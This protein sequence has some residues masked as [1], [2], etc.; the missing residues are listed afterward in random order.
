MALAL[1]LLLPKL[2]AQAPTASYPNEDYFWTHSR[3]ESW[4]QINDTYKAVVERHDQQLRRLKEEYTRR[5]AKARGDE[6]QREVNDWHAGAVRELELQAGKD[7]LRKE[8]C[9]RRLNQFYADLFYRENSPDPAVRERVRA[10][11]EMR[12]K[13]PY[14]ESEGQ[15]P[16]TMPEMVPTPGTPSR[17][18]P[19]LVNAPASQSMQRRWQQEVERHK[20]ELDRIA[21]SM[22][23]E[24]R[25]HQLQV[26]HAGKNAELLARE[27]SLHAE[28]LR[29][30][31]GE[32]ARETRRFEEA[33]KR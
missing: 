26:D 15:D 2:L 32:L 33:S 16:R 18:S 13:G 3:E 11:R 21:E 22:N 12:R 29:V 8:E 31:L 6:A 25:A 9:Q 20:R 19:P 28:R 23:Q 7:Y 10:E 27:A 4:D 5:M 24:I 1:W 30:L 17:E 14:K